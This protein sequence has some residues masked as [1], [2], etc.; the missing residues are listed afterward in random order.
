MAPPMSGRNTWSYLCWGNASPK[1][2][3]KNAEPLAGDL[4][5]L[6]RV[7]V[8]EARERLPG[9]QPEV[10]PV[11]LGADL[12]E[13]A[14]VDHRDV[15]RQRRRV[16]EHPASATP[17]VLRHDRVAAVAHD[18]PSG[19]RDHGEA[20]RRLEVRLVE[21]GPGAARVVGL[22]RGPDV[23]LLVRRV[24]RTVHPLAVGG[25]GL[26]R[27]DDQDVVVGQVVELDPAGRDLVVADGGAVERRRYDRDGRVDEGRGARGVAGESNG[28]HG[29]EVG[30]VEQVRQVD[31]DVVAG[32]LEQRGAFLGFDPGETGQCVHGAI[33]SG[34]G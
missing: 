23:D 12:V 21:A 18:H 24:D 7:A 34:R 22:E 8:E 5:E 15:R 31:V 13:R 29:P 6:L 17:L 26:H 30:S 3:P 33:P 25:L 2:S 1:R 9:Q 16:G 14:G 11:A 4:E 28:G 19:G 20:V 10:V 32:D 27:L